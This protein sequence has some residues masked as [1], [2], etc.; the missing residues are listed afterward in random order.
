MLINK[1]WEKQLQI[2][3]KKKKTLYNKGRTICTKPNLQF[4]ATSKE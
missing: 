2:K 3:A 1:Q 4:A